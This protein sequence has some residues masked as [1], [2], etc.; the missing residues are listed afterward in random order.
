MIAAHVDNWI[1]FLL[2]IVVTLFR[3]L[4]SAA[5]KASKDPRQTPPRSTSSPP[6]IPRGRR[7]TDEERIRK[8][9]DALGQPQGSTPPSSVRARPTYE[10]PDVL[11]PVLRSPLPPL[12]TKPPELPRKVT[13]PRQITQPPYEQKTFKPKAA[14]TNFE[15]HEAT[16]APIVE[17]VAAAKS[18]AEAYAIATQAPVAAAP[19]QTDVRS[20]LRSSSGLRS[21]VILREVFGP[22]RSLQP[23]ELL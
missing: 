5:N 20:L 14:E 21:A 12:T 9:L 22:P 13:L 19:A 17:P 15:V 3:W 6:P 11:P 4:I 16:A 8:F 18:P 2:V 7:E 10:K 1:F 23:L